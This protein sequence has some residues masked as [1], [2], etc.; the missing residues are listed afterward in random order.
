[1]MPGK[2]LIVTLFV[3][4]TAAV[5]SSY[6]EVR[7]P[8]LKVGAM[9]WAVDPKAV[10][11]EGIK[12]IPP[13]K[14][15]LAASRTL[16]RR[17]GR[18]QDTDSK[19][20]DERILAEFYNWF[21]QVA[22]GGT[23]TLGKQEVE[24]QLARLARLTQSEASLYISWFGETMYIHFEKIFPQ[25]E[26]APIDER[27]ISLQEDMANEQPEF[28]VRY[29]HLVDKPEP[30][31]DASVADAYKGVV[32]ANS[33]VVSR[34]CPSCWTAGSVLP[35]MAP[36]R[37]G[38]RDVIK[39]SLTLAAATVLRAATSPGKASTKLKSKINRSDKVMTEFY[40]WFVA[41]YGDKLDRDAVIDQFYRLSQVPWQV[42][43]RRYFPVDGLSLRLL[44]PRG[45]LDLGITE[46]KSKHAIQEESQV[47]A[48]RRRAEAAQIR[49]RKNNP[50]APRLG[51]SV[52][53][54]RE[55]E[56]VVW[57]S[58]DEGPARSEEE[59]DDFGAEGDDG[60]MFVEAGGGLDSDSD[61]P[62]DTE[63]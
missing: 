10:S 46:F 17:D 38:P 61:D 37:H 63:L 13:K 36:P 57:P 4:A 58:D 14:V 3:W 23:S 22:F 54:V 42:A 59:F 1:M 43:W 9:N 32:K 8:L 56:D 41:G 31:R 40:R 24:E 35:G 60:Y 11:F 26:L 50:Q 52:R 18:L 62:S 20:R 2:V 34:R 7:R 53:Q 15:L 44:F 49:E 48:A 47:L 5:G 28:E 30:W 39:A 25:G 51:P 29:Q 45:G 12:S 19:P 33:L 27:N 6:V 16:L 55:V 21:S